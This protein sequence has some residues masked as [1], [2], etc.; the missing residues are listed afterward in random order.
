MSYYDYIF[1]DSCDVSD[2]G[3][4][5]DEEQSLENPEV[6]YPVT[7]SY[8]TDRRKRESGRRYWRRCLNAGDDVTLHNDNANEDICLSYLSDAHQIV[9]L[10]QEFCSVKLSGLT[11]LNLYCVTLQRMSLVILQRMPVVILQ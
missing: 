3:Y 8:E 9:R 6:C 5:V 10:L 7:V 4:G 1:G 11:T 2:G